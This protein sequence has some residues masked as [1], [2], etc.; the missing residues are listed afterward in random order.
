MGGHAHRTI[1]CSTVGRVL[2]LRVLDSGRLSCKLNDVKLQCAYPIRRLRGTPM[3]AAPALVR[4]SD[5][6]PSVEC[7]PDGTV[8]LRSQQELAERPRNVT[9]W[10]QRWA[11]ECPSQPVLAQR[12]LAGDWEK[13]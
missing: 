10:L 8:Y 6:S 12:N 13:V 5:P 4:F 2:R 11:A 1:C 7:L 3:S 9:T